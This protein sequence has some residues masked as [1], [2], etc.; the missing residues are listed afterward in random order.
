[1]PRDEGLSIRVVTALVILGTF[2]LGALAGAGLYH[3]LRP[4]PP[5]PPPMG[6]PFRELQLTDE[7]QA[8]VDTITERHRD[9][10]ETIMRD[11]YPKVR[12]VNEEVEREV[13]AIL[14]PEQQRR[15]DEIKARRPLPRGGPPPPGEPFPG[16]RPRMPGGPPP[17]R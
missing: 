10:L 7:Q 6:L 5:P 8:Q 14:T 9:A 12:A 16:G 3:W 11:T 15:L 4:R 2:L 1:M 13:R 17:P